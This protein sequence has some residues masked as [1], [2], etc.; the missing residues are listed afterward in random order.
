MDLSETCGA[1]PVG[2]GTDVHCSVR[3]TRDPDAGFS[4]SD[5]CP[6]ETS[7]VKLCTSG[8]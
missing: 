4:A 1:G 5:C 6:P 7:S 8:A 3:S 2:G